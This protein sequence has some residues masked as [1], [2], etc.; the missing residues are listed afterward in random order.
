MI[1]LH[2]IKHFQDISAFFLI[3]I[4]ILIFP[5]SSQLAFVD[6]PAVTIVSIIRKQGKNL[7]IYRNNI[8]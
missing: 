6:F 4:L 1:F 5:L 2:V 7:G 3:H 8:N